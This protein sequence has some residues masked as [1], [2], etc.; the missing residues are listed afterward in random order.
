M[1]E[2]EQADYIIVGGGS[3]GCV[4]ANRLSAD[5]R[6]RV[7]MLE[8][9]GTNETIFVKVPAGLQTLAGSPDYNWFRASEPD[10]SVDG[11]SL[12]W[13]AGKGL[14]GGSAINGMVYIRGAPYDYDGWAADG[15]TGWS[16]DDVLPYFKRSEDFDGPPS[17]WHGKGGPLGVS[18]LRA[19]HPL[20]RDF[21]AACTSLGLKQ[22]EDYCSGDIDGV[23]INHATQRNGWR[24]S[25]A[26]AFLKPAR[27][28]PNLRVLTGALVDRVLIEEG[29][30]VGV[31]YSHQGAVRELRANA[32]VILSAGTMPSPLILMRSGVGPGAQLREHGIEVLADAAQVG[33]NLHEHPTAT[34][35]RLI[36][37]AS[38]NVRNNPFRLAGEGLKYLFTRRG[39]LSTAAVHSQAHIRTTPDL[40]HPDVKVQ[41]LPFWNDVMVRPYF[42]PDNP[43][44]DA[45][46]HFGVTIAVNT[47]KP[48]SRGEVRLRGRDP[49]AQPVIDF[50][51]YDHPGDLDAMRRGLQ[52]SNRL[53]AT[54]ALAQHVTGTAYPPDP[55]QSDAEWDRQLRACTT[56]GVHAVGTCAMGGAADSVVDPRLR[57]R[58]VEGLRVADCS[59]MPE[60]PSANTNA[61]VIMLAE[62]CADMVLEDRR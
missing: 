58:G 9:G 62:K 23:Y 39:W 6:N 42:L 25:A 55:N 21:I 28:R 61:P 31:R 57:V 45:A 48:K 24:C 2:G 36:R 52:F 5:P 18:R 27:Q 35:S 30:A 26:E 47:V 46:K 38:Y 15:C 33:R 1:T 32:E 49:A 8:A 20:T 54:P 4:L 43:I 16:W 17:E 14:G 44:P 56:I 60:L 53:F 59:V 3:A 19:I 40:E 22:V 7:V 29:R 37:Q 51:V 41:L 11:R 50:R 34:N 13:F 10:P 12:I